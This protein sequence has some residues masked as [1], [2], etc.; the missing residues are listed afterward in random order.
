M[1]YREHKQRNISRSGR[2]RSS[3]GFGTVLFVFLSILLIAG[4]IVLSPVGEMLFGKQI[5]DI[6]SCY[7]KEPDESIVS[8]LQKQDEKLTEATPSPTP[9]KPAEEVITVEQEPFYILQM[10]AY[11]SEEK[12]ESKAEEIRLLGA[13]GAVFV[14]GSVYRVFA[15]AYTDEASLEKV[16]E[17]VRADGFEATPYITE[18]TTLKITLKGDRTAIE[19]IKNAIDLIN[20]IPIELCRLTLSF[21]KGENDSAE[22]REIL[23][24]YLENIRKMLE[25]IDTVDAASIS[26][27]KDLLKKYGEN[28]S[29]FLNEHDTINE[30][31]ISGELKFLQLRMIIDY[32]LFFD[33][34]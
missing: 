22:I 26:V 3:G 21:D 27:V 33:K 2:S 18:Q 9:N 17:Q 23:Q 31:M 28:I 4:I 5:A 14:D 1:E 6:P 19:I 12:A 11:T 16:H 7:S 24:D 8:A 25:E 10:G 13:G 30:E 20:K 15:A 29:T 32:I 34:E